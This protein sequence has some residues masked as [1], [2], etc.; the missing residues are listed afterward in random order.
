LLRPRSGAQRSRCRIVRS[1]S[2]RRAPISSAPRR[3]QSSYAYT[4]RRRELHTNP[5][6][7][8]GS[9]TGTE[10]YRV[11]PQADGSLARTLIARDGVAVTGSETTR[12]RPRARTPRRSAVA[13]T[14]EALDLASRSPRAAGRS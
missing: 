3:Q 13:D 7:R 1:C 10:E 11:E 8:L 14:A 12:S 5:F 6:G 4:E 2:K 9:G